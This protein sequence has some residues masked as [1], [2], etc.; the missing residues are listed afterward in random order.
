MHIQRLSLIQFLN[1]QNQCLKCHKS[2]GLSMLLL[3]SSSFSE[4]KPTK[5]CLKDQR[6]QIPGIV[7]LGCSLRGVDI[8]VSKWSGSKFYFVITV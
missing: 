2:L 8:M 6:S 1:C 7:P 5:R 4:G 3:L